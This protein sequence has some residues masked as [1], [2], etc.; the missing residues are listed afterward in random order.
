MSVCWRGDFA[1]PDYTPDPSIDW[2]RMK[3]DMGS[4]KG[5]GDFYFEDCV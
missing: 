4:V 5:R 3:Y 1:P 2:E